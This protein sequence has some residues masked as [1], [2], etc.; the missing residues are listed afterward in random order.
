MCI[1]RLQLEKLIKACLPARLRA[2]AA[3]E[4]VPCQVITKLRSDAVSKYLARVDTN[5]D[6]LSLDPL[7]AGD[8]SGNRILKTPTSFPAGNQFSRS[9]PDKPMI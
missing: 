1:L 5:N 2:I 4:L 3:L 9:G 6:G 7:S 8:R